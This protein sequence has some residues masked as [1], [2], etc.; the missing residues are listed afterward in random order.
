MLSNIKN[1]G[2]PLVTS[3]T[4]DFTQLS[5]NNEE[6]EELH[7]NSLLFTPFPTNSNQQSD[8]STTLD[9]EITEDSTTSTASIISSTVLTKN[10]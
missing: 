8:V 2:H 1:I 4:K 7:L 3:Q 6:C 10:T 5:S 9:K